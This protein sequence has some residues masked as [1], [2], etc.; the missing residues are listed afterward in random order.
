M[1]ILLT[2]ASSFSGVWFAEKLAARG[3]KVIAP[4]RA[5]PE[6]YSGVRGRRV[7]RL[8]RFAEIVPGCSFGDET[9]M[10]LV[11]TTAFDGLC[12]H[13]AHVA[14][15]RSMDFDVVGAVAANTHNLRAVLESMAKNG[16]KAVVATGSVFEQDEGAGNAPMRAFSPYGLSKG[17]TWQMMRYWCAIL[18]LPLGKFVIANPFGPFEEPRFGA[19]LVNTWRK[20]ETAEVRTP[21]YLRDNIHVDL[22]GFAYAGFVAE[23]VEKREGRR[24][25]PCGYLETQGA[26]AQRVAAE[27]A[28]R[29]G[30]DCGVRLLRQTDFAEPLARINTD[31]IDPASY[32]WSEAAA[33]DAMADFYRT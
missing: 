18:N 14:D 23:C 28:P 33:W 31:V 15:Y 20:G 5:A 32:G 26:F 13:A 19:Y 24:F 22:L 11:A 6:T 8:R 29:L 1:K 27:L 7:E 12:H 2:G 9:F 30:F 21:R 3:A 10:D 4:L 25:G 16:L 17:L